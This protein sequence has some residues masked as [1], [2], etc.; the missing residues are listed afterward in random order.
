MLHTMAYIQIV[1]RIHKD[2]K[3]KAKKKWR[4]KTS[5]IFQNKWIKRVTLLQNLDIRK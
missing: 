1:W 3:G 5:M 2:V 4:T